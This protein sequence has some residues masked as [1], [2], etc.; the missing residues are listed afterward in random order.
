MAS[1]ESFSWSEALGGRA[2]LVLH[3][4]YD[5]ILRLRNQC[6]LDP[7]I[8]AEWQAPLPPQA[9]LDRGFRIRERQVRARQVAEPGAL[10]PEEARERFDRLQEQ[11]AA[12]E[13][14]REEEAEAGRRRQRR[15]EE[16]AEASRAEE[17]LQREADAAD[18]DAREAADRASVLRHQLEQKKAAAAAQA[19]QAARAARVA[20]AD[21]RPPPPE[22][23]AGGGPERPKRAGPGSPPSPSLPAGP[24]G[25]GSAGGRQ[26]GGGAV[27][28]PHLAQV[29]RGEAWPPEAQD[30]PLPGP[31]QER[32]AWLAAAG[33]VPAPG[34]ELLCRLLALASRR[35]RARLGAQEPGGTQAQ[36][37]EVARLEDEFN[38]ALGRALELLKSAGRPAGARH[39][40]GQS[41][42]PGRDHA[43]GGGR[44]GGRGGGPPPGR[45]PAAAGLG[46]SAGV[47][48]LAAGHLATAPAAGAGES[49]GGRAQG[50][51]GHAG[52]PARLL[53]AGA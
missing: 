24:G 51:R 30:V 40:V 15:E 23:S 10:G 28:P 11:R 12:E 44:E 33:E 46:C 32:P 13:R 31:C 34:K 2:P 53:W 41:G 19:V 20:S 22:E 1:V 49:A 4:M 27:C 5:D 50:P 48:C 8:F 42:G 52:R 7:A 3:R 6:S 25:P 35:D 16:A 18:A 26:G 14:A 29:A 37:A 38:M 21:G 36:V 9:L 43:R 47:R 17:L 39:A 45:A